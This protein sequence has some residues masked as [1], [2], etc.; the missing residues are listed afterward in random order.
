MEGWLI[1]QKTARMLF[2]G[3]MRKTLPGL[4]RFYMAGQWVEPGGGVPTAVASGQGP[5]RHC[6]RDGR[7]FVSATAPEEP[8]GFM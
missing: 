7:R 3:G 1:T 4:D 8:A 2:T 5:S 6:K